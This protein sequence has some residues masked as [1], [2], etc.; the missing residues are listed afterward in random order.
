MPRSRLCKADGVSERAAIAR[1][2]RRAGFGLAPGE[3]DDLESMGVDTVIDRL[4]DPAS[5]AIPAGPDDLWAGLEFPILDTGG[6]SVIAVTRW[7]D[8]L[9]DASRPFEEWTAWYWHGHLVSSIAVVAYVQSKE[10]ALD[11]TQVTSTSIL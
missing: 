9:L 8:H 6:S 10:G 3:L 11:V 5:H 1:L 4:V 7:L 2:Y